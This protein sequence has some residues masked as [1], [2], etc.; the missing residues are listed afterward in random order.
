MATSRKTTTTSKKAAAPAPE[1]DVPEKIPEKPIVAKEV[2][3]HEYITVKNGCHGRLIYKSPRTG[4]K[5]TWEDFGDEQEMELQELKNAKG[6][7][8]KFFENNWFMFDAD[9]QWVIDYLGLRQFYKKALTLDNFDE[10]FKKNP[11]EITKVISGLSNGQKR[12]VSYR[13]RQLIESGEID[14]K[15]AIDALEKALNT[16]LIER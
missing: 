13:A 9:N 5:F 7:G 4:E 15:K 14:S 16:E 6:A 10:L 11:E 3:I 12:T 2:D 1:A 8:K